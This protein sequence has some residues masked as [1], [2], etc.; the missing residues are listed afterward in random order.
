MPPIVQTRLD[1][2]PTT[3]A[4]AKTCPLDAWYA[5]V[6]TSTFHSTGGHDAHYTF[7]TPHF[8]GL[9]ESSLP[10][11]ELCLATDRVDVRLP[12][13]LAI[14]EGNLSLVKTLV[15]VRPELLTVDALYCAAYW[16]E[17]NLVKYLH[18]LRLE[19]KSHVA[20]VLAALKGHT[21]VVEYLH[22][23]R[24][25]G[26]MT[27]DDVQ[28]RMA[29]VPLLCFVVHDHF[30]ASDGVYAVQKWA[31]HKKLTGLVELFHNLGM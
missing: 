6:V 4:V 29:D 9:S 26:P 23:A 12:L 11:I 19:T 14:F 2:R 31:E 28:T 30:F 5:K 24:Y 17:L 15:A 20:L 13:H 10:A 27:M 16:G 18:A 21:H 1:D 7:P 25:L 8:L 22:D 3:N